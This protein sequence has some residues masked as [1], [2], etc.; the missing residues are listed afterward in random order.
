MLLKVA[1]L[2]AVVCQGAIGLL[3]TAASLGKILNVRGFT[4]T[5]INYA[6]IPSAW[7]PFLAAGLPIFEFA[8]GLCLIVRAFIPWTSIL[9]ALLFLT[10]ALAISINIKRGRQHIP[11]GCFGLS[12]RNELTWYLVGRNFFLALVTLFGA[13]GK[14]GL[15]VHSGEGDIGITS[16]VDSGMILLT[17]ASLL[18]TWI[19]V[20]T[21]TNLRQLPGKPLATLSRP[22]PPVGR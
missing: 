4:R 6:L 5:V 13:E 9:V 2:F 10:F 12:Q 3:L 14:R 17:S 16:A 1:F 18:A 8:L 15:Q 11:C 7:A 20:R 22:E 19:L 21:F